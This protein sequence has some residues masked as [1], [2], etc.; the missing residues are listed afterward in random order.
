MWNNMVF[1]QLKKL[2]LKSIETWPRSHNS[3]SQINLDLSDCKSHI[4]LVKFFPFK[5]TNK[6]YLLFLYISESFSIVFFL[7]T[8]W[9]STHCSSF[10]GKQWIKSKLICYMLRCHVEHQKMYNHLLVCF[11]SCFS[12]HLLMLFVYAHYW[13]CW[14]CMFS[15]VSI[16]DC[17]YLL[18]SQRNFPFPF[19]WDPSQSLIVYHLLDY[20]SISIINHL[21]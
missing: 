15:C 17:L 7:M 16:S 10:T 8:F 11:L 4:F 20:I 19:F 1:L 14:T 13:W 21:L 2:G 18:I 6:Q 5:Y 12:C 9:K 3:K